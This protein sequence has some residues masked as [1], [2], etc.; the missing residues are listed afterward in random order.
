[1]RSRSWSWTGLEHG[2]AW[3]S[4]GSVVRTDRGYLFFFFSMVMKSLVLLYVKVVVEI[5]QAGDTHVIYQEVPTSDVVAATYGKDKK[6]LFFFFFLSFFVP[7]GLVLL[8]LDFGMSSTDFHIR[9]TTAGYSVCSFGDRLLS[10]RYLSTRLTCPFQGQQNAG[11]WVLWTI[12]FIKMCHE[13]GR[14]VHPIRWE[15]R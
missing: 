8:F 13:D 4:L 14:I 2:G 10:I 12:T 3:A 15:E 5:V 1:M 9:Q 7:R 11:S 6:F